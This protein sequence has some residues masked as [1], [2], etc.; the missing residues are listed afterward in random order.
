MYK[1]IQRQIQ[2]TQKAIAKLQSHTKPNFTTP[3]K[4][5]TNFTF[6]KHRIAKNVTIS[7]F[8]NEKQKTKNEIST[9]EPVI[10]TAYY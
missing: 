3:I 7:H 4:S 8:M 6:Q 1:Q 5:T 9:L 10:T 2:V